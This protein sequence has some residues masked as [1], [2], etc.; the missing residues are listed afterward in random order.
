[1]KKLLSLLLFLSLLLLAFS[2]SAQ[3]V[4]VPSAGFTLTIPDS[5]SEIPRSPADDPELVLRLA[6]SS[7]DLTVYVSFS[8]GGDLFQLLTGDESEYGSVTVNG[9][10]MLYA[11]GTDIQG[12][13]K[14]YSWNRSRD[15]ITLYFVW[16][17]SQKEALRLVDSIM[18]SITFN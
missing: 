17:G 7:L 13:Y 2:A 3:T 12:N 11:L 6:D 4:S 8:G 1:M 10:N 18:S 9:M 5:F 14:M 16:S 15:S